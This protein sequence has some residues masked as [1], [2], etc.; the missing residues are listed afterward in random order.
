MKHHSKSDFLLKKHHERH[1]SI[2]DFLLSTKKRVPT[3]YYVLTTIYLTKQ[4]LNPYLRAMVYNLPL[5]EEKVKPHQ[6]TAL[7]LVCAFAFIGTGAIITVY[8]YTIPTYGAA[9][10]IAG[11]ALLACTIFKNKWLI[12][13]QVNLIARILECGISIW[14]AIY[15]AL[16]HWKF[17]EGIF[18]AI[19]VAIAFAMYWE[20]AAGGQLFVSVDDEGVRFPIT[21]R[22]RFLPWTEVEEIT[23]RYGTLSVNSIDNHLFQFSLSLPDGD[24]HTFETWC[25]ARVEQHKPNRRNDDW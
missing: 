3:I 7:H 11:I 2:F 20:R 23:F 14:L 9:L 16:Q 13:R 8:N 12:S 24:D 15:S 22:K 25:L 6:V 4:P 5:E 10:L 1:L 19:T 21:S 17:P 18:A